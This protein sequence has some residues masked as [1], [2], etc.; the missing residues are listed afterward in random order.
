M[1]QHP[2]RTLP[3]MFGLAI[4]AGTALLCLPFA[5]RA[6]VTAPVLTALFTAT[7]ATSVTG[8]AVVDT[9][10][11]WSPFGQAVILCLIQVGG[12]G[13]MAGATLLGLLIRRRLRLG[14]RLLV[15]TE[16]RSVELS[17]IRRVLMTLAIV[18]LVVELTLTGVLALRFHS[19]YDLAPADALW[20]GLFHAVSAFN[21]AGFSTF[22]DNLVGFAADGYVLVPVSLA[23]IVGGIGFPVIAELWAEWRQPTRWSIHVKLTLMGT[24]LLL[25][26]GGLGTAVAEWNNPSTLGQLTT[27]AK[28][29]NAG[30]H[31]VMSRTAGFNTVDIAQL[32][33]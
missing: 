10:A 4:L 5:T 14:R 27:E 9:N 15:Q 20:R 21:N 3:L 19:A 24:A 30:V 1:V 8:L 26:V 33:P 11:F 22:S 29:L 23:V 6:G 2:A 32:R 28:V 16:T 7:S 13:I 31:A 18:T 12:F 25:V 17:D